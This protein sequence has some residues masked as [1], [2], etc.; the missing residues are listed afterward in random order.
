VSA[1]EGESQKVRRPRAL[2]DNILRGG[3]AKK[4]AGLAYAQVKIAREDAAT[5]YKKVKKEKHQV[6]EREAGER[7]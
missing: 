6:K 4:G 5:D 3:G 7:R 2:R 1:P